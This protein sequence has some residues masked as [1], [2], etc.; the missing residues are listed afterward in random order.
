MLLR[1]VFTKSLW[2]ARRSLTG[3]TLAIVGVGA[4][5]G[6]FWPSVQSPALAQAMEAY[7]KAIKDALDF[8]LLSAAGYLRG[9]VYGLL[10]PLLVAIFAIATGTRA[11]AGDEEAGTL[12]LVLAYPVGRAHLALQRFGALIVE[13]GI[14]C[15]VMFLAMVAMTGPFGFDGISAAEFAATNLQL[16]LFGICF[17]ALAFAI[18]AATGSRAL[19][20]WVS[21]AVAVL[22][23]VAKALL[24]Q[25]QGLGWAR[26]LSP[27]QWFIGGDPLSNGLQI[28][29]CLLLLGTAAALV[30]L[31]T[32]TFTRR[33]L[34]T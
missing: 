1:N 6:A 34:A 16:A 18:G 32:T 30:A 33:D 24:P 8:D 15:F 2:D 4:M 29:S 31:G 23:Y 3:W 27:F 12:D 7:P 28:G 25:V 14:V 11:V 22:A 20:L 5:Y 13:L 19:A 21:A 26:D 17:G 10:V 9:S